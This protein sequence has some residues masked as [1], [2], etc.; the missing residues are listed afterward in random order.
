MVESSTKSRIGEQDFVLRH[1]SAWS[2][3]Q[4][5]GRVAWW[6][7][8]ATLWRWSWHNFYGYRRCLLRLFGA[9]V[10]PT[11]RIRPSVRIECPWNISL[12]VSSV[13][14]DRANI[15]AVGPISIADR[16]TISQGA[17]LCAGSHDFENPAMPLLR[18]PIR[19][20][21]DAWV[22]ADAFVGPGVT[23]GEGALLGARGCAFSDLE[24]W[25][26]YGG[27]PARR[28]KARLCAAQRPTETSEASSA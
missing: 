16:C 28:L 15:Y 14:G 19:I 20:Q 1:V 13:I 23:V 27:N 9:K 24:P 22:A 2:F 12:G 7:V 10:D 11:A 18:C 17:H 26:I 6:F 21:S 8:Q 5:L 4:K 25:T 3:K